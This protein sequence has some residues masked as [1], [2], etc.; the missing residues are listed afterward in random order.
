MRNTIRTH[1]DELS[2][3]FLKQR[4]QRLQI[5]ISSVGYMDIF[6]PTN[7]QIQFEFRSRS[8]MMMTCTVQCSNKGTT[9][10]TVLVMYPGILGWDSR[11]VVGLGQ[12][13]PV[14]R[15]ESSSSFDVLRCLYHRAVLQEWCTR[16][17]LPISV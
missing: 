2:C 11:V 4:A 13:R 14:G 6:P 17:L 7:R 9:A 8:W 5:F 15:D 3:V 16:T 12:G 10:H 1:A